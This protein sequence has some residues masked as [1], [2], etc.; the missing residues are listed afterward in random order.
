MT[1]AF[2]V[3]RCARRRSKAVTWLTRVTVFLGASASAGWLLNF[4]KTIL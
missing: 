4:F 1:L 3:T 2:S